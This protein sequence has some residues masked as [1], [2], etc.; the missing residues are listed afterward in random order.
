MLPASSWDR[1]HT[2]RRAGITEVGDRVAIRTIIDRGWPDYGYPAPLTDST[3]ANY[4][5]FLEV[6]RRR[7]STVERFRPGARDQLVLRHEPARYPSVEV[8]NIIGNGVA[9]TGRGDST[10]AIFPPLGATAPADWPNENMCSLGIRITYGRFRYFTGGDLPGTPDPG[11]PSWHAVE[12][13]IADVVGP[14]D[15]HV[16]NQHGSMGE[17]S[18]PFLR[19]LR[20]AVLIV[21]SWA[22]SHPAPDVLKRIVNSRLAPPERLVFMTDFRDATRTVI[23]QRANA[24]AGPPGHVVVRVEAGGARYWVAVLSNRDESGTVVALRGPLP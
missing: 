4:R 18:E 8:R 6:L 24:I 5:R 14:V 12:S 15:V 1:T 3:M 11:F 7:G 9:W 20:S 19:A 17:E 2:F 13:A 10:R 21:P 22:P 23:G 16:V